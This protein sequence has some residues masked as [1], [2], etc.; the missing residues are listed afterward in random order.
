MSSGSRPYDVV[1]ASDLRLPGGT[2]A[3]MAEEIRAQA[4]AG[5]RTGLLHVPSTLANTGLGIEPRLR[6]CLDEGL[7]ELVVAG[8]QVHARLAVLRN[9]TVFATVP[10]GLP[11]TA[12]QALLVANHVRVD[13]AGV[14]HYDVEETDA[15]VERWLGVRPTWCSI[16]PA[17]R[18]T[19]EPVADL[20]D[21]APGDWFNLL[22]V[23]E[24]SR[25]RSGVGAVPV[26]GRHS[27]SSAA[28]WPERSADIRAAYPVDDSVQVRVLGG[29][30]AVADVLGSVP[31]RWIVEE[32][33]ARDPRDFVAS[34]DFFVYFHRSDLVE[35]YGR[36]VMEA[37]ASGAV[38]ILPEH[39]RDSFGDAAVYTTPAGVQDVVR[40]LSADPAAYLEQ[41]TRGQVF[42]R[43]RHGH[44][45]HVARLAAILGP[46]TGD[47]VV[48]P[49]RRRR[50]DRER[51]LFVSS[52]GA[53]MGHLTRLLAMANRASDAV[54]PM[55]FSLS[56]AVAVVETSGHPWEYCPSRGDL[57]CTVE[58]WNPL[59]AQR[60]ADVLRRYQPA[61]V[62]FDGTMPYVGMVQVR[63]Q[64]PEI[65]FVW[66][67][68]GMWREETTTK[69]LE[70]GSIFD[71]VVQP[72][73]VAAAYD[74]GPVASLDDAYRVGPVTLLDQDDLLSRDEAR[75][76]LGIEGDAPALL[77]SLGAGNINDI[78][79]DLDTFVDAADDV[80]PGWTLHATRPPIQRRGD[81]L[82]DHVASLSVYPLSRYLRAFD[83]AVVACGYNSYHESVLA[84]LPT[85]FVPNL[86]TT[87]D[88]QL[89]RARYADDRGFGACV[90]EV[91]AESARAAL[92]T[93]SDPAWV[94]RAQQRMADEYPGNGAGD[95][96]RRVERLLVETKVT[97]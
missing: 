89:G 36:T 52:N 41:S 39:F 30:D 51:V 53:G 45:A 63:P 10:E 21:V 44:E 1:L 93:V 7:A 72:G 43:G 80:L 66:S 47:P 14:Q 79:S 31:E 38:A 6:R 4:A 27:R 32:F 24:W 42:V 12:D 61:A 34:L 56:Q 91:D 68:R 13:A 23:D 46:P 16:G 97:A 25:E 15:A 5:Y 83:A 82:R 35:A 87:T 57:G 88:D 26:L 69:F 29:A 48:V 70:R 58:Q 11:V 78:G 64:F 74:R 17:V 49:T 76:A 22:D 50:Q 71:L 94:E 90:V 8:Q 19:L 95:A 59:F 54:E 73:E 20:V 55:F 3:S 60:F 9:A 96:M 33:G 67:R 77:L 18:E 40:R 2:T 75:A 28:K 92:R 37:M 85:V 86:Q 81:R 84:G 62:V 65:A